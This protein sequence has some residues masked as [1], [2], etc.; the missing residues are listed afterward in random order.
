MCKNTHVKQLTMN[1]SPCLRSLDDTE[2]ANAN[3]MNFLPIYS[4]LQEY[5]KSSPTLVS[6]Q[7]RRGIA[8]VTTRTPDLSDFLVRDA[9]ENKNLEE[10]TFQCFAPPSG[11]YKLMTTTNSLKE[12]CLMMK[13]WAVNYSEEEMDLFL[14]GLRE[15]RI[16]EKFT[17]VTSSEIDYTDEILMEL[18]NESSKV[19][20]LN[21]V[22]G[23]GDDVHSHCETLVT[24]LPSMKTLEHLH[25]ENYS[26]KDDDCDVLNQAL[27]LH[28]AEASPSLIKLSLSDCEF[29]SA[30]SVRFLEYM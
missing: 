20:D 26:F 7:F 29:N 11:F 1:L 4:S 14:V 13:D 5:L 17:L 25:L 16:P 9:A 3:P 22:C 28:F 6:L 10:I 8:P 23:W 30:A 24:F 27:R 12:L 19:R 21:L 18:A 2:R 15:N